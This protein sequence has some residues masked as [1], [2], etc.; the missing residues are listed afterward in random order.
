[1]S[2]YINSS[3]HYLNEFMAAFASDTTADMIVLDAGAGDAPYRHLFNHATYETADLKTVD[4]KYT[5]VTYECDLADIPVDDGRFD[6]IIFNQVLEHI[7]DPLPVLA[8][9]SRALK[10]GGQIICS[11]PLLFEEHEQ[12]YDFF[13]YTQFAYPIMFGKVGF[14]IDD[15]MWLEGYFGTFAYQLRKAGRNIPIFHPR[16]T[17]SIFGLAAIPLLLI[18]KVLA[19]LGAGLFSRLDLVAKIDDRGSP[20]N[21]V[22]I[23]HKP[24]QSNDGGTD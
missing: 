9:L 23:A 12:P 1:M 15:I 7:P 6:R 8:E 4:K 11:A 13:R 19:R 10:P 18:T 22:V 14:K 21:Y 3:R 17:K 2:L 20:K 16:L 5:D 24:I